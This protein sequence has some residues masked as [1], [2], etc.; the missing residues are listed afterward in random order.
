MN[1][2]NRDYAGLDT[3]IDFSLDLDSNIHNDTGQ[4]VQ[5]SSWMDACIDR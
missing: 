3:K 1:W 4:D 5:Q 2:Y